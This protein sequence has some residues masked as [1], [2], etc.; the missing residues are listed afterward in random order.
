MERF[1]DFVSGWL[2]ARGFRVNGGDAGTFRSA[3]FLG[4]VLTFLIV[5]LMAFDGGWWSVIAQILVV[6][7]IM[8]CAV[9]SQLYTR[10]IPPQGPEQ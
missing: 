10:Q 9:I 6:L 3:A 7:Y 2:Y 5:G 1:I 4:G 8:A